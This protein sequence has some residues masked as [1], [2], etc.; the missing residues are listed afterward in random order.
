M[1]RHISANRLY[2]LPPDVKII[3]SVEHPGHERIDLTVEFTPQGRICPKCGSSHCWIKESGKTRTVRHLPAANRSVFITYKHR[4]YFCNDCHATY[5]ESV[6]W[7]SDQF[8]MTNALLTD[9]CLQ[10][11]DMVSIRDIAR[12]EHITP[13]IVNDVLNMISIGRPE[14]LPEVL[15]VD[16]FKGNAGVW[17]PETGRWDKHKF[18]CNLTDG[19]SGVLIDV[20]PVIN[21]KY[22]IDYFKKFPLEERRK[23]KFFCCD[24][25]SG[26]MYVAKECFPNAL[27]CIDLFHVVNR[28]NI[29]M[30]QIRRRIQHELSK[31]K[32]AASEEN[33]RLLK[34]SAY[35]L[36]TKEANKAKLW[37]IKQDERQERLGQIL[38]LFPDISEMY[39]RLQEFLVIVDEKSYAIQRME[40][41]N[42]LDRTAS[43]EVPEIRS[44]S[45]TLRHWRGYIQN[46]WKYHHS[47]GVCEGINNKIKVFKRIS[48]GVHSFENFRKRLLL[49]C[50]PIQLVR[51]P[52]DEIHDKISGTDDKAS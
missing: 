9:I 23:V 24:M 32:S 28:V 39:D 42:W 30:D 44:A 33:Y 19:N 3:S 35:I 17:N 20:L 25:H 11:T 49:I 47:S 8:Q 48:F 5:Y 18:L 15:C 34:N 27:I 52:V 37:G 40:F 38:E 16:E 22:L 51:S 26:F 36:K 50:G 45:S 6:D 21:G 7:I 2:E 1:A 29:A 10:L 41:G 14:S 46:G 12:R 4:R 31:Q 43:S 13:A